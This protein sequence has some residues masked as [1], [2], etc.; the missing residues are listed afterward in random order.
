MEIKSVK[1]V[2]AL[3]KNVTEMAYTLECHPMTLYLWSKQGI[4]EK[5]WAK[6]HKHYGVLPYE[7]FLIN[8]KIRGYSTKTNRG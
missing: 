7:C 8:A 6:L 2:R 5:Y 3:A 1:D 4:H